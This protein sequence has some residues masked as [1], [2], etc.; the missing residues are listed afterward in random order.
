MT[1]QEELYFQ[2]VLA[3]LRSLI[4]LNPL[5]PKVSRIKRPG[6]DRYVGSQRD[7]SAS[8]ALPRSAMMSSLMEDSNS[9]LSLDQ[10]SFRETKRMKAWLPPPMQKHRRYYSLQ[11]CVAGPSTIN[12]S[13]ADHLKSSVDG[14]ARSDISLSSADAKE[15]ESDASSV[16]KVTSWLDHWLTAFGQSALDPSRDEATIRWLLDSGSRAVFYLANLANNMWFNL[17]LKRRD[18]VLGAVVSDCSPED[19]STL[20]NGIFDDSGRLFAEE[21]I[22]GVAASTRSRVETVAL[23]KVLRPVR[24]AETRFPTVRPIFFWVWAAAQN[25]EDVG[26]RFR[27]HSFCCRE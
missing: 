23:R 24:P 9:R 18:A 7:L 22:R 8:F 5:P 21:T 17:R 12:D 16:C 1:A 11:D 6:V 25:Q 13:L 27:C 14:A 20:R 2:W 4:D 10:G 26:N 3:R 15:L 19:L